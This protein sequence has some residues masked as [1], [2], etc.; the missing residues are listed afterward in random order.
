MIK[1]IELTKRLNN[2]AKDLEANSE[3]MPVVASN[4][5]ALLRGRIQ[6]TGLNAKGG[7]Y[8]AYTKPYLKK[9]QNANKYKGFVDFSFTNRMWDN[10][11]VVSSQ[12]DHKQGI[13]VIAATTTLEKNKLKGNTEK[14]GDILDLSEKEEKS[15]ARTYEIELEKLI[16]K[17][18]L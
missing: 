3:I 13:A 1:L 8:E 7:K 6:E 9:K 16:K 17:H 18:G 5:L 11:K 12:E 14:K 15:I 4:A 10:I 2:L